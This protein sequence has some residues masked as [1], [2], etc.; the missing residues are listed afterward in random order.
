MTDWSIP[1]GAVMVFVPSYSTRRAMVVVERATVAH[2]YH[3]NY[4]TLGANGH[5]SITGSTSA[6]GPGDFT[7]PTLPRE[8]LI[9]RLWAEQHEAQAAEIRF[10]IAKANV[11][12]LVAALRL[13]GDDQ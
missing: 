5:L 1:D 8:V 12:H 4:L 13:I 11:E 9:E 2:R 3:A 7:R 6:P 10:D